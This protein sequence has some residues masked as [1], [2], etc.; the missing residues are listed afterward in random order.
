MVN[1]VLFYIS[2]ASDMAAEREILGRA[3]AEVPVDLAWRVVQSPAGNGPVDLEAVIDADLHILVMGHDIR[4]PVGLEWQVA[5]RHGRQPIAYLKTDV[6]RT[7]AGREFVRLV[8]EVQAWTPFGDAASLRRDVLRTIAA[9]LLDRA[10]TFA[11]SPAEV[12]RLRRWQDE[13]EISTEAVD[14]ETRGGAGDSAILISRE[15]FEPT[16]GIIIGEEREG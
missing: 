9:Y 12:A 15:R 3:L 8:R 7:P 16:G 2:A 11:L 10:L 1:A 13:L 4:A 6:L 5:R 14:E